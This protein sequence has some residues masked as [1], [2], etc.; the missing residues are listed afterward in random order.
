MGF[1]KFKSHFFNLFS[2]DHH[3][4]R[5]PFLLHLYG[6]CQHHVNSSK[7]AAGTQAHDSFYGS[8]LHWNRLRNNAFI[9]DVWA[10]WTSCGTFYDRIQHLLL[11]LRLFTV[12]EAKS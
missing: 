8:D 6:G 12:Q 7:Q 2:V 4:S 3:L 5:L 10:I 11:Y 9:D 1:K